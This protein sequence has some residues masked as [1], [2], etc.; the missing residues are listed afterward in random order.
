MAL[1]DDTIIF[2]S[3]TLLQNGVFCSICKNGQKKPK[4]R[5]TLLGQA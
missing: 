4:T 5:I 3:V 1:N 2:K